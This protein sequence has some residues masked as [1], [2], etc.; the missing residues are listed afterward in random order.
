MAPKEG[1]RQDP[2]Y[3]KFFS[4]NVADFTFQ[5]WMKKYLLSHIFFYNV[6]LTILYPTVE[7]LL[8]PLNGDWPCNYFDQSATA[9][10]KNRAVPV[11]GITMKWSSISHYLIL[12]SQLP[13]NKYK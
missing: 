9:K 2:D 1:N 13:W 12:G 5:K 6:K 4:T 3:D 11:A 10:Y 8:T 7:P